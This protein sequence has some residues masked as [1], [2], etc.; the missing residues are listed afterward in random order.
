MD[1]IL[2]RINT[3]A[4]TILIFDSVESRN[5]YRKYVN[6]GVDYGETNEQAWIRID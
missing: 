2:E 3:L 5:A 6:E 1:C 4:G